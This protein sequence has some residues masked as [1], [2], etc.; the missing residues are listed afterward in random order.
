LINAVNCGIDRFH[1]ESGYDR[2]I[3]LSSLPEAEYFYKKYGFKYTKT[4]Y[5]L[6]VFEKH[7]KPP[8]VISAEIPIDD[9]TKIQQ[10]TK[11]YNEYY[12][13][14]PH[15]RKRFPE[16]LL[17]KAGDYATEHDDIVSDPTYVI[18]KKPRIHKSGGTKNKRYNKK[19]N[20]HTSNKRKTYKRKTKMIRRY[21]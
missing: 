6:D 2:K 18:G 7:I 9:E 17:G 1:T 19:S 16:G 20:R 15:P 14:R 12:D 5:G 4:Q 21:K 13:L 11:R 10:I 8:P 3:I